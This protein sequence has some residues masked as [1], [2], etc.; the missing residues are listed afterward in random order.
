MQTLG[1]VLHGVLP[2][3]HRSR[4]IDRCVGGVFSTRKRLFR[5][6]LQTQAETEEEA[7]ERS[8]QHLA[9]DVRPGVLQAAPKHDGRP[10]EACLRRRSEAL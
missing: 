3:I 6:L 5:L 8:A 10:E 1:T 2:A 4:P 9:P 7:G